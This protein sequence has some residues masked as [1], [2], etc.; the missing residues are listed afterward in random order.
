MTELSNKNSNL[1]NSEQFWLAR[2]DEIVVARQVSD[3]SDTVDPHVILDLFLDPQ[4]SIVVE[5]GVRFELEVV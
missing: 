5:R 1:L 3:F 2:G 4:E